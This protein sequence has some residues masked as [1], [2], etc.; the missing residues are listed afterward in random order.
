MKTPDV[1]V[2][3]YGSVVMI[4][5]QSP[6]AQYRVEECVRLEGWQWSGGSFA[7]EPRY[8]AHLVEGMIEDG[9]TIEDLTGIDPRK[10]LRV[11]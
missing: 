11:D 7:C 2:A 8:V 1:V 4:T 6:G 3:C 5:P 10:F 9:L